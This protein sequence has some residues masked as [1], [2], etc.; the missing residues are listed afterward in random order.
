MSLSTLLG[1]VATTDIV[2][3]L[4]QRR[5]LHVPCGGRERLAPLFGWAEF[6]ASLNLYR[7]PSSEMRVFRDGG[8]VPS[9][10]LS[11]S[12]TGVDIDGPTFQALAKQ[13]LSVILN[14]FERRSTALHSAW[15][16]AVEAF[17]CPLE[18]GIISTFGPGRALRE[19]FDSVDV[20]VIQV[21]GTKEWEIIGDVVDIPTAY[22]SDSLANGVVTARFTMRPGDVL[23]LPYGLGHRCHTPAASL[24]IGIL[25]QRL[26]RLDYL[27]WLVGKAEKLGEMRQ[28]VRFRSRGDDDVLVQQE[29]EVRQAVAAMMEQ[30]SLRAFLAEKKQRITSDVTLDQLPGCVYRD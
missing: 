19:H 8:Q 11:G 4:E 17:A 26:H 30:F 18:L 15:R 13:G 6:V 7:T 20:V 22:S 25:I 9:H 3:A 23:V 10:W 14:G 24:Q 5:L 1:P 27:T 12:F 29:A 28:P 16:Q 21:S 2:E